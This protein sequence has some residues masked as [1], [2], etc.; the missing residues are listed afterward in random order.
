MSNIYKNITI[1]SIELTC[2]DKSRIYYNNTKIAKD[3]H[4]LKL[5]GLGNRYYCLAQKTK[6]EI[7]IKLSVGSLRILTYNF[8]PNFITN[9]RSG[10]ILVD[11]FI[12]QLGTELEQICWLIHDSN[13]TICSFLNDKHPLTK[14]D[15]DNLL[16]NMLLFAGLNKFK[17]K[18]IFESVQLFAY[19]AYYKSDDLTNTNKKLF[20]FNT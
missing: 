8:E 20:S 18:I 9:F 7:T 3:D 19:S 6:I 16:Y 13:Y 11:G 5:Y 14:N 12:D 15:A 10:G 17:D 4:I 2:G 1:K